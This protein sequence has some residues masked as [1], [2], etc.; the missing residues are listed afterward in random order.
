ME[1][2]SQQTHDSTTHEDSEILFLLN[3]K[4]ERVS[5]KADNR[6][7]HSHTDTYGLFF[8]F[9]FFDSSSSFREVG[10]AIYML[11]QKRRVRE[12]G[13]CSEK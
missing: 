10:R 13:T 9:F 8:F 2:D 12:P 5:A 7:T 1:Q 6:H 3:G 11:G 4:A